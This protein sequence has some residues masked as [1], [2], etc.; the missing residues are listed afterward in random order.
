MRYSTRRSYIPGNLHRRTYGPS[1]RY[2][3]GYQR[4]Y[5]YGNG[6][7]VEDMSP[8]AANVVRSLNPSTSS[9]API[10]GQVA[11]A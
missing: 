9:D 11:M 4:I 2:G 5:G 8:A 6:G 3:S 10:S 1:Q 7:Q